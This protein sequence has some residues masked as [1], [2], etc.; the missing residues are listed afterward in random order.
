MHVKELVFSLI[1]L[2][3]ACGPLLA[4]TP[5]PIQPDSPG[6]LQKLADK[7]REAKVKVQ[8]WGESVAG[9]TGAYYEDH[10]QPLT[11]SYVQWASRFKSSVLETI[12]T[13]IDNYKPL[14]ATNPTDQPPQN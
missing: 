5:A 1:L 3:Q 14:K 8:G 11:D 12:Q 6:I 10:I 13:T 9:F 2:L 7:A 4:Q